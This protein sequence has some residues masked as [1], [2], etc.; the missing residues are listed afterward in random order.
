MAKKLAWVCFR[1][2]CFLDVCVCFQCSMNYAKYEHVHD[3]YVRGLFL[4]FKAKQA[5]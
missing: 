4:F 3:Y 5:R 2:E 1:S